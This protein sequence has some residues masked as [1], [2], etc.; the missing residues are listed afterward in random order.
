MSRIM[1]SED[2]SSFSARILSLMAC[3]MRMGIYEAV[4]KYEVTD[5]ETVT[6][7]EPDTCHLLL[8]Y[9][10]TPP[11]PCPCRIIELAYGSSAKYCADWV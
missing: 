2:D 7:L 1:S 9:N 4:T 3:K 11:P 10:P 6:P 8:V 5:R